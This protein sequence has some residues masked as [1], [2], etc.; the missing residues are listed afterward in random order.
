[1][2]RVSPKY[3][4]IEIVEYS[5]IL[6][7]EIEFDKNTLE[8]KKPREMKIYPHSSLSS[9]H[10]ILLTKETKK[11]ELSGVTPLQNTGCSLQ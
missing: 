9:G 7:I 8:K 11:K 10:P 3:P 6:I 5:T 2:D 1:M 4:N